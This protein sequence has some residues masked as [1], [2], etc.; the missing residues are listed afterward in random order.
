VAAT[1]A[2]VIAVILAACGA[3]S[4]PSSVD[5]V[6]TIDAAMAAG[7][8]KLD[9]GSRALLKQLDP[10]E[11]AEAYLFGATPPR[12][13]AV[14]AGLDVAPPQVGSAGPFILVAGPPAVIFRVGGDASVIGIALQEDRRALRVIASAPANRPLPVPGRPYVARP[15]VVAANPDGDVPAGR[16]ALLIAA[17]SKEI[18]TIDGRPYEEVDSD[19]ESC[20][21]ARVRCSVHVSGHAHDAT[22]LEA[23][24][25]DAEEPEPGPGA[26]TT[27]SATQ[28]GAIPRWL[29]REAERIARSDPGTAAR[30]HGYTRL[31]AFR[32][33]SD[34]LLIFIEYIGRCQAGPEGPINCRDTLTVTVDPAARAVVDITEELGQ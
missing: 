28:S 25:W 27:V 5:A 12:A 2:A 11:W 17:L 20:D 3:P 23:D 29:A 24:D 10:A 34:K 31:T 18:V 21:P 1:V 30:I 6:P 4:P 19:T 14:D 9:P 15:L 26:E 13:L 16:R 8:A 22:F 32:W 7:L 33:V